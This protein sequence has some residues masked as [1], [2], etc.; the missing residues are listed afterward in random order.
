VP[1]PDH[2]PV[3][4][5]WIFHSHQVVGSDAEENGSRGLDWRPLTYLKFLEVSVRNNG[6]EHDFRGLPDAKITLIDSKYKGLREVK[7]PVTDKAYVERAEKDWRANGWKGEE[8]A[9]YVEGIGSPYELYMDCQAPSSLKCTAY[10]YIRSNH[11]QYQMIFP[12]NQVDHADQ[13]IRTVNKM[14]GGWIQN[15]LPQPHPILKGEQK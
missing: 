5:K 4:I 8:G 10:V 6:R 12:P 15:Q 11:F 7:E 14:I 13:L 3:Y 2:F 1:K 9:Y